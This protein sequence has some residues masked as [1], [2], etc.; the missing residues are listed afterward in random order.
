[1]HNNNYIIKEKIHL[2]TSQLLQTLIEIIIAG[3]I[4]HAY[5]P[6]KEIGFNL[7]KLYLLVT[8]RFF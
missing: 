3:Y 2:P 1:M 6:I 7:N 4:Y 8:M 5:N